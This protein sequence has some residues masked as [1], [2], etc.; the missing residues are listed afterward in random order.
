MERRVSLITL[1]VRDHS[2]WTLR[3]DGSIELAP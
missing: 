1:G 2:Q 3:E